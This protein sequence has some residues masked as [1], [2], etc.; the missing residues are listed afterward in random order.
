M[1]GGFARSS[2]RRMAGRLGA[3]A[4]CGGF[5]L[6]G[7][8]T[9][10]STSSG[11][12]GASAAPEALDPNLAACL[13]DDDSFLVI[14]TEGTPLALRPGQEATVSVLCRQCCV[15]YADIPFG[16]RWSLS[17]TDAATIDAVTG[18]LRVKP[19]ASP[20][21]R[22]KVVANLQT[23]AR[24]VL[25]AQQDVVV[26]SSDR[27]PWVGEWREVA[28]LPC[29]GGPPKPVGQEPGEGFR[30][31]A[32]WEAGTFTA[33]WVPFETYKDFW[34]TYRVGKD[35]EVTFTVDGG[36]YVPPGQD[37]EGTLVRSDDGTL[38]L[39]GIFLGN[40]DEAGGTVAC[41]HVFGS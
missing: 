20:G 13:A 2:M 12:I 11:S 31:F 39:E 9:A 23:S 38:R 37:L 25:T 15:V 1:R 4:L 5:L 32:L 17:A 6:L 33:T 8:A 10:L 3:G 30:E 22:L 27:Q 24:G 28:R 40:A 41:G 21:T 18:T 14:G 36:N 29:D 35:G 16:A 7:A 34:G 26:I 19:D